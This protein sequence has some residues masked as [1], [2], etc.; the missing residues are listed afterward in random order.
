MNEINPFKIYHEV[1]RRLTVTSVVLQLLSM[2]LWMSVWKAST[3]DLEVHT[4]Y[5][6]SSISQTHCSFPVCAVL[7]KPTE[8]AIV[9]DVDTDRKWT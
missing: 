2:F 8:S 4:G 5:A 3:Q 9:D 6:L 1:G 7:N